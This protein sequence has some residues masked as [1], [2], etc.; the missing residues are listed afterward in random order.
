M[1]RHLALWVWISMAVGLSAAG[2]PS[3]RLDAPVQLVVNQYCI[4]CHDGSMK[5]GGLDLEQISRE[6]VT[7]HSTEWERVI[8]KL[9]A[10][11]MP[12]I[13]KE[14]PTGK[15]YDE[16]V[17]TLASELD[18]KAAKNPNPGRTETFRRL[19]RTE[20]QNAIRDLLALEFDAAALLPKDE[21]SQGF[22]N[23]EVA[24]LSPTLLNRYIAAA[25]KI[26]RL[27]VGAPRRRPGGDTFRI[28]P[29]VT[30]EE[31]FEGLPPGTRGGTLLSYTFPRDGEYEIQ[32]RLT[33]DRN[34][35]VEG[36]REPHELEVLLDREQVKSFTVSPPT[37]KNFEKVDAHLKFRIPVTAGPHQLGVTFLKN[38]S[39]LLETKRQPYQA[40]YNFHRHPRLTPAI[41]QISIN[42][43]YESNEPG[44]SPSRRRIFDS[45]SSLG[46]EGRGERARGAPT[47]PDDNA[48]AE[49]ILS[50]LMRRAYRRPVTPTDLEKPMEFYRKARAKDGFEAGIE[51]ALSAVLVSP[52]FLFRIEQDPPSATLSPSDWER[53]G[54]RGQSGTIYR[55][56]D[57]A[58]ASR[59][60]FFLW[61]SIPDDE[62]LATAERGELHKPK[63][64]EKQVRRMLADSRAENLV[65]NFAEQWLH[66]RNLESITPDLR[67]FPDFDDNL[68]QAFRRETEMHFET[69]LRDDRS[70]LDLLKADYTFVN[71]RL[72]KHYGIPNVYGS[73]FRRVALDQDSERGGLLRQGSVL[74]V[75]SYATRTSPVIRG[76]WVLE[77]LVGA[78]PPPPLPDVP[79]LKDNTVA[80]N[81]SVR[82]RLAEHRANAAC[83]S[84][85][86]LMDPIGFSLENF[87][88]IGRWR[89]LEDGL[90]IDATGGLPDGSKFASVAGLEAGL[91]K[92]PDIFVST[93]TEKLLTFALGRGVESY[94]APAVRKIVRDAR[95]D[96]YRFSSI[97]L[98]IANSTPFTMR[99]A[100]T[101][102]P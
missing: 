20:Y 35:E 38:P 17:A 100:A 67:L 21:V 8:R 14:R 85:H 61:S 33:R 90:P 81:L 13:G 99:K 89:T 83:A 4:D 84:C 75:T 93:L 56:S 23:V 24:N 2:K 7:Q 26:S 16:V 102:N 78:P 31:H 51:A 44:D 96:D 34:E 22:D 27:A 60:S 80:A 69:I 76:K 94:D 3:G 47:K 25:E 87:D 12:P 88:A 39:A 1:V 10:R 53:A 54:V 62:L 9:R 52:E 42:G 92:R 6:E 45:L 82:A 97:I 68:R 101:V 36:L 19:N 5:K 91:L 64:L 95:A 50:T 11:Q 98:G 15:I 43:P 32:I 46:G 74:T 41:Y 63:V 18:R 66:L 71:E 72:A 59:L 58:L 65:R 77:N 55:I 70:V 40:H 28:P 48:R 29:D 30:Q 57:I 79:A 86:N 73:R 49:Q 37:D